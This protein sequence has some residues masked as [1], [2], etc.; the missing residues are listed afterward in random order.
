LRENKQFLFR[1]AGGSVALA[2]SYL[3]GWWDSAAVFFFCCSAKAGISS[4]DAGPKSAVQ[5]RF[6]SVNML[7][8]GDQAV[9]I[10]QKYNLLI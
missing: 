3:D 5:P 4:A 1:S 8:S 9:K 10:V 2:E 6:S 7:G